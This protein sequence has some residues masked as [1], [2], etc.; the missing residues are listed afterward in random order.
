MDTAV[1]MVESAAASC[2]AAVVSTPFEVIKVRLQLQGELKRKGQY[3]VEYRGIWS[4]L[5]RIFQTEGIRG[6]QRGLLS[7][8]AHQS[9]LNGFRLGL[10]YPVRTEVA[11]LT[12]CQG[13][14]VDAVV[15][16]VCGMGGA[17]LASPL[18]LVKTRLQ[19]QTTTCRHTN[20][21]SGGASNARHYDGLYD[22]L[23]SVYRSSGVAGLMRGAG[24][25]CARTGVGSAVQLSGYEEV[26]R[27]TVRWTERDASDTLVHLFSSVMASFF[28]AMLMNPLDV[29]MTRRFNADGQQYQR[30][31]LSTAQMIVRSEGVSGLGKGAFAL[32]ARLGPHTVVMFL[33]LEKI[34]AYRQVHY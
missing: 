33:V 10:F 16:L 3:A 12:G 11:R 30:N 8:F 20:A 1:V 14:H 23:R 4:G 22:G 34:R 29:I 27:L 2:A 25:S 18:F 26:K 6:V 31:L 17:F 7:S 24:T 21:A 28:G 13:L 9:I 19:T 32:W 15:G 5:Y